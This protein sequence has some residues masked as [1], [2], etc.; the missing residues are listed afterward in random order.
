MAR[1]FS[2]DEESE[3]PDVIQ[4]ILEEHQVLKDC[5]EILTDDDASRGEK[6]RALQRFIH[7][8]ELHTHAEEEI[9]YNNLEPMKEFHK[10][11]LQAMEEHNIAKTLMQELE[12]FEN[13]RGLSDER[14][15]KAKVLA[16]VVLHHLT[17]EERIVIPKMRRIFDDEEL[18]AMGEEFSRLSDAEREEADS[19]LISTIKRMSHALSE[20]Y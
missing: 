4:I 13:E 19:R 16:D 3:S 14:E 12:G 15:A 9:I 8:L 2:Y 1:A 7:N 20:N 17:E 6:K 5:I 11:T 18:Q 10:K